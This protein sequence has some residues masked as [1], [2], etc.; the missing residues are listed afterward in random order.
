MSRE[1]ISVDYKGP[2]IDDKTS[3]SDVDTCQV[4]NHF[5]DTGYGIPPTLNFSINSTDKEISAT[6]DL[7]GF[8]VREKSELIGRVVHFVM[9][10][11]NRIKNGS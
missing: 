5:L 9:N 10:E 11:L 3:C 1:D 8:G 4:L 6:I 7:N 2:H